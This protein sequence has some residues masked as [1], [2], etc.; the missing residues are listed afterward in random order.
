MIL[1]SPLNMLRFYCFLMTSSYIHQFVT[2]GDCSLL[3]QDINSVSRWCSSNNLFFNPQKTKI[4]SLSTKRDQVG[5]QYTLPCV[6]VIQ[7][8]STV[9]YLGV[10]VDSRL[11]FKE[12]VTSIVGASL[13][14]LGLI[15]RITHNFLAL[16][17]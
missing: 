6:T 15:S 16:H 12:Q 17:V 4:I 14:T 11:T 1:F 10:V 7:S 2:L 13:R 5:F 9:R 3:Q 8:V